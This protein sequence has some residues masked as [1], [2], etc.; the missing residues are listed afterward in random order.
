MSVSVDIVNLILRWAS[1]SEI[2]LTPIET[3]PRKKVVLGGKILKFVSS[4]CFLYFAWRTFRW[5]LEFWVTEVLIGRS[6]SFSHKPLLCTYILTGHHLALGAPSVCGIIIE[7]CIERYHFF[8]LESF[9]TVQTI[10]NTCIITFH[11]IQHTI[12]CLQVWHSFLKLAAQK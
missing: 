12:I 5:Y 4:V 7:H 1:E 8:P 11:D 6:C 9:P 2:R 10:V 3:L